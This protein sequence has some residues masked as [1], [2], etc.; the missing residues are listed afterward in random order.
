MAKNIFIFLIILLSSNLLGGE[1]IVDC[2]YFLS[3]DRFP[4]GSKGTVAITCKVKKGYHITDPSLGLFKVE[5]PKNGNFQ[6]SEPKYPEPEPYKDTFILR[7]IKIFT[8]FFVKKDA[9]TGELPVEIKLSYQLCEEEPEERCLLP[10]TQKISLLI[11]VVSAKSSFKNI[12]KEIFGDRIKVKPSVNSFSIFSV[13]T[14]FISGILTGLTPCVYPL[15]PLVIAFVGGRN[16]K[17]KLDA[18]VL[19]LFIIAGLALSFSLLGIL[20][21]KSGSAIG[22]LTHT[23]PFLISVSLIFFVMSLS[24]FGAFEIKF[25]SSLLQKFQRKREG[26]MSALLM[27]AIFGL[28]GIP[29]V[30]PLLVSLLTYVAKSQNSLLGF[31]LL[32][33]YALGIGIIFIPLSLF[34]SLRTLLSSAG[35]ISGLIK[36]FFGLL[37]LSA[38][39]YFLK[40]ALPENLYFLILGITLIFLS[41]FAGTFR[42]EEENIKG[43]ILKGAG[44]IILIL[45]LFYLMMSLFL[46]YKVNIPLKFTSSE[47]KGIVWLSS[48]DEGMEIAKKENKIVVLDFYADWCTVCKE[49]DRKT[50]SKIEVVE[51]FKDF[52]PVR[53]NVS[54]GEDDLLREF[55]VLGIPTVIFLDGAGKELGRFSG[56]KTAEDLLKEV[57]NLKISQL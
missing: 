33:S 57:K 32:F 43:K 17:G 39:F 45:G 20:S 37:L 28:I 7:D 19:S 12:N 44:I 56:F 24:M 23:P 55:N 5:F 52:V 29:C 27:G 42:K 50:F 30:G 41:V 53:I 49:L 2:S 13:I 26:V 6:F 48:I 18:F 47:N 16:L 10:S 14:V 31:I 38:S 15:Y 21:A 34:A 40:D 9:K 22:M 8:D 3:Q 1:K 46:F 11:P 36:Y 4:L 25:P 54:K 51:V 35:E